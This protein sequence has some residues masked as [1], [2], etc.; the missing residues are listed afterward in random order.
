MMYASLKCTH[1]VRYDNT[2]QK[3]YANPIDVPGIDSF[4]FDVLVASAQDR[5]THSEQLVVTQEPHGIEALPIEILD[6]ICRFLPS[7]SVIKLHRA[8][9]T[10]ATKVQLD[11][12]FWRNSLRTGCL[13]AHIWD[14]DTR[15]IETLRQESNIIFSTEGWDWRS[16]AKLL[17]TK[18]VP[19][20]GRDPRLDDMPPGLW[21][22]S[23]I[24]AIVERALDFEYLE[25]D[26]RDIIDSCMYA[27]QGPSRNS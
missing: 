24:W 23:R 3:F 17:A 12:A 13:H 8:S 4:V 16:V 21:N 1:Y 11:N 26:K 2:R 5:T 22:R 27:R 10:M 18:K 19:I 15:R 25:K 7:Q 9:K 6:A 14:I 20:S